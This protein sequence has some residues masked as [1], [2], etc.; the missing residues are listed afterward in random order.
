MPHRYVL[1]SQSPRRRELL[2]ALVGE[3]QVDVVPPLD[4]DEPGFEDLHDWNN[5]TRR[6]QEI[7]QAKFADV[8]HQVADRSDRPVI[9]TAD[10]IIVANDANDQCV[11][12]GKPPTDDW[13]QE[14]RR[15][16]HEYLIGGTHY[17]ATAVCVGRPDQ[18]ILETVVKT[19]ITFRTGVESLVDWYIGTKEPCGKAGGYAIQGAGSIFVA[20]IDGSLSNVVGL[21]LEATGELIQQ[22]VGD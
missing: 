13:Q 19:D 8:S 14:V 7:S 5:I 11:V 12:L 22:L 21:P 9:I 3:D 20:K 2:C 16:F 4:S 10:T 1:G 15:W 18:Q 6:L 17:A